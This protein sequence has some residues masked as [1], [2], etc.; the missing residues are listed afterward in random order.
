MAAAAA[1]AAAADELAGSGDGVHGTVFARN[2]R[3][4]PSPSLPAVDE[5][6]AATMLTIDT[7][8][9]WPISTNGGLDGVEHRSSVP[10]IQLDQGLGQGESGAGLASSQSVQQGM[11]GSKKAGVVERIPKP[12]RMEGARHRRVQSTPGPVDG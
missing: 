2:S 1:V 11:Q 8:D 3:G 10:T 7:V 6:N 9:S 12:Q 4:A 5:S